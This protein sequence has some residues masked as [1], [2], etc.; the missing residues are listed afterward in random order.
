MNPFFFFSELT[1]SVPDFLFIFLVGFAES[2]KKKG[3]YSV[4]KKEMD[5]TNTDKYLKKNYRRIK[6]TYRDT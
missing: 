4:D 5:I 3:T 6:K 1:A 2:A